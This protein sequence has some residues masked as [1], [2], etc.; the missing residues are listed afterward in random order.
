MHTYEIF[1]H[2]YNENSITDAEELICRI[3]KFDLC[4]AMLHPESWNDSVNV[5]IQNYKDDHSEQ[6]CEA[7]D[8]E[9]QF[10]NDEVSSDKEYYELVSRFARL[11]LCEVPD[12]FEIPDDFIEAFYNTKRDN[13]T[14][15]LIRKMHQRWMNKENLSLF[16]PKGLDPDNKQIIE[17]YSD[18]IQA[19]N[20]EDE[21]EGTLAYLLHD[22]CRTMLVY[23]CA[24]QFTYGA[25]F[26]TV[27]SIYGEYT[28]EAFEIF[29]KKIDLVKMLM[30]P[31]D[32][33]E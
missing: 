30:N 7:D 3:A 15:M 22:Y 12:G 19:L 21:S 27:H 2:P 9:L 25:D 13:D 16:I 23:D 26:E 5:I 4:L 18:S 31:D 6:H 10:A 1:N 24:L 11:F 14:L 32:T 29:S 33:D 20:K 8:K 17:N 28:A